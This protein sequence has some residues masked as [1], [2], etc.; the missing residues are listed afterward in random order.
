[1]DIA[2]LRTFLAAAETKSFSGAAQ[3]VNASP[4]SVTERIKQLEHR[5]G[6]RLFERSKRGCQLTA[7]GRKFL[8]P[9][10][11][12]VRALDIARH[13][14]G[15]PEHYT[16]SVAF[17]AQ[18]VLWD[19]RL[20]D[21]LAEIRIARPE[22]AWRVTSGASARLNRELSEG[23]LDI[24]VLYDPVFRRD[25]GSEPLFEDELVLVTGG[26]PASWRDDYVR[27]EWGRGIGVEIASRLDITPESGLILD[28]GGRSGDWLIEHGMSG[29]MPR[30]SVA[31]WLLDG[32]L[33]E[34]DGV[35]AFAF[36]AYVC[37]NRELE[38]KLVADIVMSLKGSGLNSEFPNSKSR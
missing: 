37:W 19:R 34:V 29:Y 7:A 20:L 8:G 17:G 28:L 21:W 12:A 9:A 2:T 24:A 10:A 5:L 14:V 1:M 13:E 27:I 30:R 23:F 35:P 36:P 15:L 32:S 33:Q 26:N 25:I 16:Q 6:A 3:R 11:Q 4:S 31:K 22:I 18:Y 38:P